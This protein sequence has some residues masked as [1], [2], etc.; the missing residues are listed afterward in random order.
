APL[1][2]IHM[3]CGEVNSHLYQV[4]AIAEELGVGFLG[5][6]FQPKHTVEEIP[7]MPKGRY[8]VMKKYMPTVGSMGLDMMFRTCT[9]QVN[10]DFENEA[11]MVE[12][13]RVSLALQP[14]ATALFANSPFTE[15]EPNGFLS[16][17]SHVWTDVDNNRCGDLPFVF[18]E[19]FGFKK[20]VEYMLDVPMY[21]VYRQGHYIDVTGQSFRDFMEGK[22]K[23]LP[24]EYP[25]IDDWEQHLS[26]AFPEVRLKKFLEMRGADSG[27]FKSICA[28]PALWV[29]LIYDEAAQKE[30][31]EMVSDW[32]EEERAYLRDQVPKL[33]LATPFRDGTVRDLAARTLAISK[34]GLRSRGFREE[35]FLASLEE[36]VASGVTPADKLLSAFET[37][38]DGSVDPVYKDVMY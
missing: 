27:P 36:V 13:F 26:T 22:L 6:G 18:E 14:I 24:G 9:V 2:T 25:T 10:L 5:L 8:R 28:L 11:D 33:G 20:Y 15:G 35:S 3:T 38:W 34:M 30:A 16:M 31:M 29:G 37:R 32:T 7:V 4:K 17:R 12:K 19:G 1:E 23:D 21:F